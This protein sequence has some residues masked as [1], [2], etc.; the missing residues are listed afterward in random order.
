MK[1]TKCDICG[2]LE[3]GQYVLF[4]LPVV[5]KYEVRYCKQDICESC[6]KKITAFIATEKDKHG[7]GVIRV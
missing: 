5:G 3:G 2:T 7:M 4:E 6:L 1:L